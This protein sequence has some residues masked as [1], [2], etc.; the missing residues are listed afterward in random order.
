MEV[1]VVL[2]GRGVFRCEMERK[3]RGLVRWL[4]GGRGRGHLCISIVILI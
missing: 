2:L 4:G 1:E 3:G